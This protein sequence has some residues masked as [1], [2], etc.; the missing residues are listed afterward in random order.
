MNLF[1]EVGLPKYPFRINHHLSTLFMGSCFT[2]NIG[3]LLKR[4]M[5]PVNINPFGVTYNPAS[6]GRQIEALLQKETYVDEELDQHNGL[7]FS[8]D[9]YTGFSS[10]DKGRVK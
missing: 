3:S 6:I 7:W 10:P 8:F 5:F 2:E 9:H 1:T 4:S